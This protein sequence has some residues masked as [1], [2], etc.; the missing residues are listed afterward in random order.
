MTKTIRILVKT[1]LFS[2]PN[3][4]QWQWQ[5]DTFECLWA[6]SFIHVPHL[7]VSTSSKPFSAPGINWHLSQQ[8]RWRLKK[9]STDQPSL[10]F[11]ADFTVSE[12]RHWQCHQHHYLLYHILWLN[13]GECNYSAWPSPHTKEKGEEMQEGMSFF[14]MQEGMSFFKSCDTWNLGN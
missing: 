2:D 14:E 7:E 12:P 5:M 13:K 11:W 8:R 9:S 10:P 6:S 3:P 1:E 4:R